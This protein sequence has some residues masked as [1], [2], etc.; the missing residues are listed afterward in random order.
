MATLGYTK[1]QLYKLGIGQLKDI[2][3]KHNIRGYSKYKAVDKNLLADLIWDTVGGKEPSE[4]TVGPKLIVPGIKIP[5]KPPKSPK[6]PKPIVKPK[7]IDFKFKS[8]DMMPINIDLNPYIGGY[9]PPSSNDELTP[10][11]ILQMLNDDNF[12]LSIKKS[13]IDI[14]NAKEKKYNKLRSVLEDSLKRDKA[15]KEKL[16]NIVD[17]HELE[18]MFPMIGTN[19][20]FLNKVDIIKNLARKKAQEYKTDPKITDVIRKNLRD[21]ILDEDNGIL[22]I[23]GD[24]RAPIRNELARQIYILS[25]G[26]RPF[27]DAFLNMVF[28]GPAGVGKT[29]LATAVGYI[30]KQMGTLLIAEVIVVSPKDMIGQYVGQTGPQTAA[31]LMKGLEGIVF[32]DEAYQIMPCQNGKIAESG[33][34]FGPEAITEIVNFLDKYVGLSIMIVAGY[35]REIDGCFF[36]AN[37]GLNRRFPVRMSLPPYSDTDLLNIFLNTVTDRLGKNVFTRE[38]ALYLYTL[39]VKLN[40]ADARI[41]VNQAGDIMNLVSMFLN[42][43]YGAWKIKWGTYASDVLIINGAFNQFLKNKGYTM[44]VNV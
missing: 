12:I 6:P 7:K 4:P 27:M 14:Y 41:F 37:E 24:A 43:Y 2:A 36:A 35:K 40:K 15:E 21:A 11:V 23:S 29:K 19:Q 9:E 28:T 20:V 30:Y 1:E 32:I 38:T 17:K 16:R 18:K 33:R 10:D 13:L 8:T 39:I 5:P 22:S 31:I 44:R 26:Y 25:K 34:S 3:K 42:S